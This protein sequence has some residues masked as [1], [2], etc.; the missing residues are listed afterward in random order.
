MPY[1]RKKSL[2][3][4]ALLLWAAML[5]VSCSGGANDQAE[6]NGNAV[7]SGKPDEKVENISGNLFEKTVENSGAAYG[8]VRIKSGPDWVIFT[9][10]GNDGCYEVS[11]I[12]TDTVS[13]EKVG[14][15]GPDCKELDR[16]DLFYE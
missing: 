1:S 11:G 7:Q 13:V 16:I 10:D 2:L 5:V 3:V 8:E 4:T 14:K 6:P 9:S 12:G 15:N